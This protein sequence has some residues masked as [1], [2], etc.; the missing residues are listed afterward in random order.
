[1]NTW[2]IAPRYLVILL[3]V[4]AGFLLRFDLH[5]TSPPNYDEDN[6]LSAAASFRTI[7]QQGDWDAL[8]NVT[9]NEE[10]PP[11]VKILY[12]FSLDDA[13]IRNI[14]IESEIRPGS[15]NNLPQKSLHA[16]RLQSVIFGTFTIL[17]TSFINPLAGAFLAVQSI[18]VNFTSLAYLDALP[19][20]ASAVLAWGY[21]S[22]LA[23]ANRHWFGISG[24]ALGVAVA[25]KY[26]FAL[27]GV[28]L[29]AHALYY[30]TKTW[31]EL[32][33]WGIMAAC[34]FYLL[35]PYIWADPIGR[36]SHQLQFHQ[37]YAQNIQDQ[38]PIVTRPFTQ[39]ISPQDHLPDAIYAPIWNISDG[40]IFILA[41]LGM[42][43]LMRKQ[44]FYGWW[45]L[46]GLLFLMMWNTQWI[47]HKMMILVP[48][49]ISAAYGFQWIWYELQQ[50][51]AS[52]WIKSRIGK[53]EPPAP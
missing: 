47:Q 10:H 26:P 11:L 43:M 1:M 8:S 17:I 48:Y 19:T 40:L 13:D 53:Q 21:T 34:V 2:K 6:Y 14:P 24:A 46:G 35:N 33:L 9:N 18:H 31:R 52:I 25:A 50:S 3:I 51:R 42:W 44:S 38:V 28:I 16:S 7:W 30:Q 12:S 45:M 22:S 4:G 20:F 32:L 29:V 15:R 39:L 5:Q 23:P 41:L 37:S 49:T 36:T 27:I